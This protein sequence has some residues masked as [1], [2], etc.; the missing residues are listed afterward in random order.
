MKSFSLAMVCSKMTNVCVP[1]FRVMFIPCV[2]G[3]AIGVSIDAAS[4]VALSRQGS[5]HV[6]LYHQEWICC[7]GVYS[8]FSNSKFSLVYV[9]N[10]SASCGWVSAPVMSLSSSWVCACCGLEVYSVTRKPI[11]RRRMVAAKKASNK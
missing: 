2:G 5:P 1:L 9:L 7:A 8:S 3:C 6:L 4:A 10:T 11:P